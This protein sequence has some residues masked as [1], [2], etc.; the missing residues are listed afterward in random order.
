ML[1]AAKQHAVHVQSCIGAEGRYKII[2]K[3]RKKSLRTLHTQMRTALVPN[4][5]GINK[6]CVSVCEAR[7]F[8]M[9]FGCFLV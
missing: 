1:R 4:S 9:I 7:L 6:M 3:K 2:L 8:N 5:V